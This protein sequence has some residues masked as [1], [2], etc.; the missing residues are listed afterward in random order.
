MSS[1]YIHHTRTHEN[2]LL[3]DSLLYI[4]SSIYYPS[5]RSVEWVFPSWVIFESS[6]YMLS[7]VILIRVTQRRMI[8]WSLLRGLSILQRWSLL[9]SW[10]WRRQPCL[11][12]SKMEVAIHKNVI[13]G[14]L[15]LMSPFLFLPYWIIISRKYF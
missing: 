2:W 7:K 12:F 10:S 13:F 8:D 3:I 5:V 15:S 14:N 11:F 6:Q 4:Y 1:I 9:L